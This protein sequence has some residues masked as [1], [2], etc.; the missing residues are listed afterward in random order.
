[1]SASDQKL[2]IPFLRNEFSKV[3]KDFFTMTQFIKIAHIYEEVKITFY[4]LKY[5][6]KHF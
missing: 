1:M 6:W 2:N 4:V 5:R 3:L